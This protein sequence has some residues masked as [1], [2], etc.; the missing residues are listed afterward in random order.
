[1]A[2][3]EILA[4]HFTQGMVNDIHEC[5]DSIIPRKCAAT[6]KILHAKDRASVQ[7][8]FAIVNEDGKYVGNKET[9]VLSGFLRKRGEAD[10]AV[11]S[12]LKERTF[13]P[14]K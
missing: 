8:T 13:L 9:V 12:I 3:R 1:M 11:D 6:N 2:E 14:F 10:K 5:V 4:T 7:L